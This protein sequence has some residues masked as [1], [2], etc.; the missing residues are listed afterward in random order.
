MDISTFI[1]E[2]NN[3]NEIHNVNH[4]LQIIK[5][6]IKIIDTENH[7]DNG[8]D[9]NEEPLE[10]ELASHAI[11]PADDLSAKQDLLN[12]FNDSLEASI[13]L[14]SLTNCNQLPNY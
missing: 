6:W 13:Y 7:L 12:L 3:I 10:F 9:V 11:H 8:K 14:S 2:N 1:E 5:N 4:Q